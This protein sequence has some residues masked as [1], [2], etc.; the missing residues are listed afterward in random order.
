MSCF[1]VKITPIGGISCKVES[2][3]RI[4]TVTSSVGGIS[5]YAERVGHIDVTATRVGGIHCRVFRTC[6]PSIKSP[7]LEIEPTIVWVIAGQT[8]ND[9]YSN[10]H[11]HI[12]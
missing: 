10:T 6:S 12:N 8:Q 2:V 1:R 3:S 5:T 7:Y 4:H 11:W 9:V